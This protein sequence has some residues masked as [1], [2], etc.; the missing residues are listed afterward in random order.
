MVNK[1]KKGG[2]VGWKQQQKRA[3]DACFALNSNRIL[4]CQ[5]GLAKKNIGEK[6]EPKHMCAENRVFAYA[7]SRRRFRDGC[8]AGAH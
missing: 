7:R 6:I 3:H 5:Q 2:G 1:N 4:R 8:H